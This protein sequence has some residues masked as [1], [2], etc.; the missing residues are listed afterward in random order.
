[1]DKILTIIIPTYNMEKY[2]R[3]CLD[4]LI[5]PN[6]DKVEVLVIN[7]GSKDSSSAIGHEYQDKYPQTFRVIDKENGNYGSCVNRGLK[8]ATGKYVK[9]LDADDSFDNETF[10]TFIDRLQKIDA[11]LVLTD[12]VNVDEEDKENSKSEYSQYYPNIPQESNFDFKEFINHD[13]YTFYGQ[14]HGF[15]YRTQ[16]VKNMRYHQTEGISYTDQEWVFMPVTKV[17]SCIYLPLVLYRYLVGRNGQTMQ[18][19]G[20]S[21]QQLISVIFS[22][23][24]F[25]FIHKK[26]ISSYKKYLLHQAKLQIGFVYQLSLYDRTVDL[27]TLRSFDKRL[28]KYEEFYHEVDNDV[29][30]GKPFNLKYISYWRKHQS[31]A[32]PERYILAKEI[33]SIVAPPIKKLLRLLLPTT[34]K[35]S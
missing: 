12:F 29:Y 34:E 3:H 13:D 23:I 17:N 32:L 1:M 22:L 30:D 21:I 27:N 20:R 26:E 19:V 8:E 14:M 4:S 9:V 16:M 7:D 28:S 10:T 18:N 24:D 15:T 25:Y 6:M 31:S 5:V 2:L 33:K 35:G 11:D